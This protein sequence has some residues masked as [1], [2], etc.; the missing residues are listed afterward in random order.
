MRPWF[1][2]AGTIHLRWTEG[3]FT[4]HTE[5]STLVIIHRHYLRCM[6]VIEAYGSGATY[7]TKEFKARAYGACRQI[8]VVIPN[9]ELE[10]E[11]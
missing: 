6:R 7:G 4:S 1:K 3:S 8:K 11:L 9:Q 10:M 2:T 5:L